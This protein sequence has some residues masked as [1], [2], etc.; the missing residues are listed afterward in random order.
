MARR[1]LV[2]IALIFFCGIIIGRHARIN[3]AL[4]YFFCGCSILL[5]CV[6]FYRVRKFVIFILAAFFC[7]G[8]LSFKSRTEISKSNIINFITQPKVFCT[9]KGFV[10]D[11]PQDRRFVF[12]VESIELKGKSFGCSGKVEVCLKNKQPFG[13]GEELILKGSLSGLNDNG[14]ASY[15]R[16]RGIYAAFVV[17]KNIWAFPTGR[18]KGSLLKR[19]A[20]HLKSRI[21]EAIYRYLEPVKA[22]VLSAMILGEKK[23]I[24]RPLYKVMVKTGTVHILVVSGFNVGIVAFVVVL[25]FKILRIKRNTRFY[26]TF[27]ILI[28]Y[29]LITGSSTPVVRATI[30]ALVFIFS[31]FVK[32]EPDIYNSLALS[33][34]LILSFN[35][36]Q[37]FDIGFQL[38][39]SSVVAIAYFY[40]R[41]SAFL[42]TA[43][44]K[45]KAIR[46]LIECILVSFSAWLGTILIIACNFRVISTVTVLA[47]LFIVPLA[48]LI[49]LCGVGL[50]GVSF[51]APGF[52]VFAAYTCDLLITLIIYISFVFS[53]LPFSCVSI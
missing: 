12:S 52:A 14:Y 36:L 25:V 6:Y 38:S 10:A 20:L 33:G 37:A 22:S 43:I 41:L 48:A 29:C 24:P 23:D 44:I 18:N 16:T 28:I 30:M 21:R 27:C 17:S 11:E 51:L 19:F 40:P 50:I 47:N 1:P 32:R 35:P 15:L 31:Y 45:I 26:F 34:L 49:T 8:I 39:F 53:L 13:Y 4:C 2:C 46:F 3:P 5:S 7:L 9:L 42:R